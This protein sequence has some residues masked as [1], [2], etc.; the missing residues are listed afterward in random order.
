MIDLR[1]AP[2]T[3][4]E[5]AIIAIAGR[6]KILWGTIKFFVK[7]L[8]FDDQPLFFFG[9]Y[10]FECFGDFGVVLGG[11]VL[12]A[13]IMSRRLRFCCAPQVPIRLFRSGR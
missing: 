8:F 11:V 12:L 6:L 3:Q 4:A 13:V 7:F 2:R 10:G 1:E 5:A 9:D